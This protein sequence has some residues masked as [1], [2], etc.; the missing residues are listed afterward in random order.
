MKRLLILLMLV[1]QPAWAEWVPLPPMPGSSTKY[2]WDPASLR[3]TGDGRRA[4]VMWTMESL[5]PAGPYTRAWQSGR[6]MIEFDCDGER[7]RLLSR[8]RFSGVMAKGVSVERIQPN[9]LW[10]Y[11]SPGTFHDVRLKA[12]CKVPLK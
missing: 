6:D 1:S 8:E 12:V 9:Q 10:S 5:V 7:E 11:P 2:F 3:K 4:W